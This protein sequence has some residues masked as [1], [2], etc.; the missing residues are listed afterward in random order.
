MK[1][2][3]DHDISKVAFDET[4]ISLIE[5]E[6]M[7][8]N[9]L[10]NWKYFLLLKEFFN[11]NTTVTNSPAEKEKIRNLTLSKKFYILRKYSLL[12]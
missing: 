12:K 7:V 6:S 1:G 4:L 8:D 9:T 5:I 3:L 10:R 2:S 11:D